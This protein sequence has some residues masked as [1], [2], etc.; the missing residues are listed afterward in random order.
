[1]L[2]WQTKK[3]DTTLTNSKREAWRLV[4]PVLTDILGEL[5][6]RQA[7]DQAAQYMTHA[8]S[9]QCA[10]VLYYMLKAHTFMAELLERGFKKQPSMG[11]CL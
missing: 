10:I 6:I 8:T 5:S 2:A 4:V 7:D 1:M 9:M 11:F 3:Y